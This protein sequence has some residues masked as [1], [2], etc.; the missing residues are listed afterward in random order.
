MKSLLKISLLML[1]LA[2][3][4]SAN[5]ETCKT[6]YNKQSFDHVTIWKN[7]HTVYCYYQAA[8][9]GL[10]CPPNAMYFILGYEPKDG[11]WKQNDLIWSC[12]AAS[13]DCR[14]TKVV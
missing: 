11:P 13:E 14:F 12:R 8:C 9:V 1:G 6:Q 5:A 4:S 3:L 7:D 10:A 2:F